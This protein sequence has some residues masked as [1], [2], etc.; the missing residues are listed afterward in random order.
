MAICSRT[1]SVGTA[2]STWKTACTAR[3]ALHCSSG[4]FCMCAS[5]SWT[6]RDL[7]PG[8]RSCLKPDD[9]ASADQGRRSGGAALGGNPQEAEV[10]AVLRLGDSPGC[11]YQ[12]DVAECLREIADHLAGAVEH[13]PPEWCTGVAPATALHN[14]GELPT[15]TASRRL[16]TVSRRRAGTVIS[17][18]GGP[19]GLGA[20]SS[21]NADSRARWGH[22]LPS[23]Q[24]D[25]VQSA[26]PDSPPR[27]L[28]GGGQ[29]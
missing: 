29:I 13:P 1:S 7:S 11:V 16:R 9:C 15:R 20:V 2:S 12:A 18:A 25:H 24:P 8:T 26:T 17:S 6:S 27:K 5:W 23:S 4:Q 19:R 3:C 22:G 28:D 10:L 14:S 21:P